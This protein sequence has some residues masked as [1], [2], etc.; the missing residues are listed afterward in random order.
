M[1][2]DYPRWHQIIFTHKRTNKTIAG[3]KNTYNNITCKQIIY[4]LINKHIR[5]ICHVIKVLNIAYRHNCVLTFKDNNK[6]LTMTILSNGKPFK[7][8]PITD[9]M[10]RHTYLNNWDDVL[11]KKDA[12]F[13]VKFI[14]SQIGI[15]Q[16]NWSF[17]E[18]FGFWL[19]VLTRWK[20]GKITEG[21]GIACL[22]NLEQWLLCLEEFSWNVH[23]LYEPLQE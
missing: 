21:T 11:K 9:H 2:T 1:I 14:T 18:V 10:H 12:I 23:L 15:I 4:V 22:N 5:Y 6:G 19:G 7:A 3:N 16:I 20:T 8:S 13:L 17:L